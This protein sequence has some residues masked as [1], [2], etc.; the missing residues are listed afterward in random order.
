[1]TKTS[2][3]TAAADELERLPFQFHWAPQELQVPEQNVRMRGLS[4]AHE[5]QQQEHDNTRS[6]G[7]CFWGNPKLAAKIMVIGGKGVLQHKVCPHIRNDWDC[8]F[9][10]RRNEFG[11]GVNY[12]GNEINEFGNEINE[13]GNGIVTLQMDEMSLDE[14]SLERG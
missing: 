9:G 1:M 6:C 13:F 3:S 12:F 10:N 5:A 2:G 7:K 11:N 4:L 14:M 8:A